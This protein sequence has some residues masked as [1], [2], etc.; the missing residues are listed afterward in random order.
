MVHPRRVLK[1]LIRRIKAGVFGG[2]ALQGRLTLLE[3]DLELAAPKYLV[4]LFQERHCVDALG[5]VDDGG[6]PSAYQPPLGAKMGIEGEDSIAIG[7]WT[8]I[9]LVNQRVVVGKGTFQC[10]ILSSNPLDL[11]LLVFVLLFLLVFFFNNI[12]T[13]RPLGAVETIRTERKGS[14]WS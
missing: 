9:E 12:V 11:L 3:L 5:Q 8:D 7:I 14:W 10:K 4:L 2:S 1:D 13:D 6:I